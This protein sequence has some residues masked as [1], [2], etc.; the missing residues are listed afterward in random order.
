MACKTLLLS[1]L[2]LAVTAPVS[3]EDKPTQDPPGSLAT[4]PIESCLARWDKGTHMTKAQWRNT[5]ERVNRERL[6]Y[7]REQGAVPEGK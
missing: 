7:L 6:D 1:L 5:C 3:A 2:A 4:E